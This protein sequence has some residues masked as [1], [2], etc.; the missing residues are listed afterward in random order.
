MSLWLVVDDRRTAMPPRW[1]PLAG[2]RVDEFWTW[3]L[4]DRQGR[5]Q[6]E[7]G[8][9]SEEDVIGG[10]PRGRRGGSAPSDTVVA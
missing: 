2:D 5:F 3:R 4:L 1:T 9:D 10:D 6:R 7:R 8:R